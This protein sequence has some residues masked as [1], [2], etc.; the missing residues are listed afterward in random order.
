LNWEIILNPAIDQHQLQEQLC[1]YLMYTSYS[2]QT[3][4]KTSHPLLLHKCGIRLMFAMLSRQIRKY[5][6]IYL[7]FSGNVVIISTYFCTYSDS[8]IIVHIPESILH[9]TIKHLPMT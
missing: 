2:L 5:G 8:N 6:R 1:T 4:G 9:Y 3:C 7:C